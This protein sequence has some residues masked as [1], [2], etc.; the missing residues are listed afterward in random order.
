MKLVYYRHAIP[1]FGD[2]LNTI[3]WPALAPELFDD[4]SDIGFVGIGTIIGMACGDLR[5]LHVFSSGTGNDALG[6]WHGRDVTYWCV[7]GPVSARVLDL[8][9]DRALTDGA[10]LVPRVAG[11]PPAATSDGGTLIIPHWQ[12]MAYP[13]WD[14]VAALTGFELLDPRGAPREIIAR[15]AGARLV[16]TESLHGAILAD[17]YGIPWLAFATSGNFG[18]TKWVDWT[19][20]LG[21][22]FD[23]TLLPPPDPQPVL[24]FG[25]WREPAGTRICFDAEAAL[26]AFQARVAPPARSSLKVR[27]KDLVKRSP[28]LRGL[29]GYSPSRTAEALTCLARSEPRM[30][31]RAMIQ[32]LQDRMLDRLAAVRQAA[33]AGG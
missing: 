23:L 15:I 9:P 11:F 25:R 22:D 20:S 19:L 33:A 27:A 16:L 8:E 24:A 6:R 32:Q 1:N 30:T 10:I 28:W 14:S 3:L 5:R 4:R 26:R 17:T 13:G 31:G 2:D 18:V 29:L 21:R 12:T 7:R